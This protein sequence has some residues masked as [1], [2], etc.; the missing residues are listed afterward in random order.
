[1]SNSLYSTV[2]NTSGV[3]KTFGFLPPHG[4]RLAANEDFVV[5]GDVR[6]ML[7]RNQGAGGGVLARA[8]ASF[9]AAVDSGDLTIIQTP[10]VTPQIVPVTANR[11][12]TAD[13]SG[14]MFVAS[15]TGAVSFTLP[16]A[17]A[18]NVEFTFYNAV[19]QDMTLTCTTPDILVVLN[20]IA[21]DTVAI[22]TLNLKVGGSFRVIGNGTKWLVI[23][24]VWGGQTVTTT[25]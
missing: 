1:M 11:V 15:G 9:E 3:A 4:R 19:N 6:S 20:D 8:Q 13:D 23:P 12:L 25:S 18:L 17:P 10:T 21:A 22:S 7:G 24:T 16:A 2:R 14:K 5:F